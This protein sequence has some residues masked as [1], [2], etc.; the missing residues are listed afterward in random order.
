[1]K[2]DIID[3]FDPYQQAWDI[4]KEEGVIKE[5]IALISGVANLANIKVKA[6]LQDIDLISP[7]KTNGS[8]N[9][10]YYT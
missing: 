7:K 5:T 9:P 1:M 2:E 8:G 3:S 10:Q 4:G 6:K